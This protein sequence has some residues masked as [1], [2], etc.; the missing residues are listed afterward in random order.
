MN[1]LKFN[2]YLKNYREK[3]LSEKDYLLNMLNRVP[4]L[5]ENKMDKIYLNELEENRN[6]K[7]FLD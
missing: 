3:N 7:Y 4:N 2:R 1:S 6:Q 5:I